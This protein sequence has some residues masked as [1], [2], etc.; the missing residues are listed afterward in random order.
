MNIFNIGFALR[1]G[2]GLVIMALSMPA[3]GWILQMMFAKM[4][5]DLETL[6]GAMRPSS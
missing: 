2:L 5:G 6:L 3:L 1:L 4:A